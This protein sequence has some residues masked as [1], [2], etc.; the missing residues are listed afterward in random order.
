M[1]R[2][3]YVGGSGVQCPAVSVFMTR[4]FLKY[5][6]ALTGAGG[7]IIADVFCRACGYNLRGL[8]H[9]GR[10]PECG[11]FIDEKA[12]T[13]QVLLPAEPGARQM[14]SASLRV[15]A[16]LLAAIAILRT[17]TILP[18]VTIDSV[19]YYGALAF[20][21]TAWVACV[22]VLTPNRFDRGGR[23]F[24]VTRRIARWAQVLWPVAFAGAVGAWVA[25]GKAG[26]PGVLGA[27][28]SVAWIGGGI[29]AFAGF[30]AF[31]WLI[32]Y[33]AWDAGADDVGRRLVTASWGIAFTLLIMVTT[34]NTLPWIIWILTWPI[35]GIGYL[36][37]MLLAAWGLWSLG[38]LVRWHSTMLRTEGTRQDRVNETRARL[39][40]EAAGA[41]RPYPRDR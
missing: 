32:S 6:G 22:W 5:R 33:A 39:D 20:G 29:I 25:G 15:A 13:A 2:R 8:K 7:S 14:I 21:S 12:V 28:S 31:L 24:R 1:R 16:V 17:A 18:F 3:S 27:A 26:G 30:S 4:K 35:V 36:V 41:I 34:P 38:G 10:C 11:L 40:A 9:G 23:L 19:V 37:F